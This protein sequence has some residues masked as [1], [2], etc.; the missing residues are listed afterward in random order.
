MNSNETSPSFID[1]L[2]NRINKNKKTTPSSQAPV[3]LISNTQNSH[4]LP[5]KNL[6]NGIDTLEPDLVDT[7]SSN[8]NHNVDTYDVILSQQSVSTEFN[9]NNNQNQTNLNSALNLDSSSS[10]S[11]SLINI[12]STTTN[13]NNLN[14]DLSKNRTFLFFI[15]FFHLSSTNL[16]K[17]KHRSY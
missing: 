7:K 16:N 14:Y 12:S 6:H 8:Q 2:F 3:T 10:S 5:N 4:F 15:I 13:K 9:N 11:S 17:N 1:K